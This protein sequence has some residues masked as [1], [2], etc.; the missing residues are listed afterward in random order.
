VP[1]DARFNIPS[2]ETGGVLYEQNTKGRIAKVNGRF[3]YHVQVH[4]EAPDGQLSELATTLSSL[5]TYTEL[6][7]TV[8]ENARISG[9]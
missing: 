1:P 7:L 9:S 4:I 5:G 3:D 8:I 6:V 2:F